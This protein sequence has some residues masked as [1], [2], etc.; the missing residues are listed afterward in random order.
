MLEIKI[1]VRFPDL[2]IILDAIRALTARAVAPAP[3]EAPVAAP[4][5][6][7]EA[8]AAP[9]SAPVPTP[10]PVSPAPATAPAA[11]P[12]APTAAPTYTLAQVAKAGA[13]L[14]T[15]D[16]SLQPKLL[17]LLQSFGASTVRDLPQDK[18]G[19]F[20]RALRGLGAKI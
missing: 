1:D 2:P 20:A 3:A 18:L 5:A 17:E 9:V 14:L 19:D 6:P 12:V 8:P 15:A 13:D 4:V 7:T 11:A 16:A 10:V